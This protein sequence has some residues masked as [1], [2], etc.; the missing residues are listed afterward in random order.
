[1]TTQEIMINKVC[2]SINRR[3]M[4]MNYELEKQVREYLEDEIVLTEY[5]S[6]RIA[7]ILNVNENC[8]FDLLT[9]LD[10]IS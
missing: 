8:I 1:M 2:Y 3:I 9:D 7:E 6:D 5:D 10:L 4:Q